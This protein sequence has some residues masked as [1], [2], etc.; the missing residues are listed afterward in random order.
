MLRL[1]DEWVYRWVSLGWNPRTMR[2]VVGVVVVVVVVVVVD[3]EFEESAD[4]EVSIAANDLNRSA[5]SREDPA[6]GMAEWVL[7]NPVFPLPAP[8]PCAALAPIEGLRSSTFCSSGKCQEA[9][10]ATSDT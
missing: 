3:G 9:R 7:P 6:E 1:G 10:T 2:F 5:R 8:P 4:D